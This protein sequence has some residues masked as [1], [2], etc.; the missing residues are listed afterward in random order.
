MI[1]PVILL[2]PVDNV[3]VC[4]RTIMAGES[5]QLKGHNIVMASDVEIGHKIACAPIAA[6]AEIIKYGMAIGSATAPIAPGDWV[7]V[8]NMR[9]NYLE[10]H[11]RSDAGRET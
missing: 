4:R 7:H 10:T 9:S 1:D 6:G 2:H 11:A 8:H 3:V 5:L